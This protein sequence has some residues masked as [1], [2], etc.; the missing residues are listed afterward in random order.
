MLDT[1]Q[2]S[3]DQKALG[4]ADGKASDML[5][6]AVQRFDGDFFSNFGWQHIKQHGFFLLFHSSPFQR[7]DCKRPE[8]QQRCRERNE[9]SFQE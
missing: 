7:D 9:T 8:H 2:H 5:H 1:T 4:T 6:E 3:I